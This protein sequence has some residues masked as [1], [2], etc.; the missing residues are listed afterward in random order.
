MIFRGHKLRLIFF[1][2]ALLACCHLFAA[3]GDDEGNP[4]STPIP[5]P[6]QAQVEKSLMVSMLNHGSINFSFGLPFGNSQTLLLDSRYSLGVG[7]DT[8]DSPEI[9]I[10]ESEGQRLLYHT[11]GMPLLYFHHESD[12]G[13]QKE[14]GAVYPFAIAHYLKIVFP[15]LFGK[16][17]LL[18]DGKSI[19]WLHS[20]AL[21]HLNTPLDVEPVQ[22]ARNFPGV[23]RPQRAHQGD[24]IYAIEDGKVILGQVATTGNDTITYWL[25]EITK[26]SVPSYLGAKLIGIHPVYRFDGGVSL[27]TPVYTAQGA[28]DGVITFTDLTAP[29]NS[30]F[31]DIVGTHAGVCAEA[32]DDFARGLRPV[33][34]KSQ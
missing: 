17:S 10:M 19:N 27:G 32:Y 20:L 14:I 22:P 18:K 21:L 24:T 28:L 25:R 2:L 29:R 34:L 13:A 31:K 30:G 6:V 5:P 4:H 9:S 8:F 11:E 7:S 23:G 15:T 1:G 3:D 26:G 12:L 33:P 16:H